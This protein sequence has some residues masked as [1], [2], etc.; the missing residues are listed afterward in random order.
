MKLRLTTTAIAVAAVFP[1]HVPTA[2][3][4]DSRLDTVVVT[5]TRQTQRVDE[6]LASVDVITRDEIERAGSRTLVEVLAGRP[7]VQVTSNGGAGASSSV[8]IRGAN[9][10]HTLLLIDGMRVG[11]ATS[12][13]PA[14]ETIPLNLIE[15]VEILRGPAS[16]LYGADAL[17]G[18]IQ[19]VTRRDVSGFQPRVHIGTGTWDTYT[20]SAGVSG[21]VERLRYSLDVGHDRTRGFDA[22]PDLKG[23][24]TGDR[25]GWKNDYFNGRLSLGFRDRDEIG[26]SHWETGGRNWYDSTWPTALFDHYIDKRSQSSSVFA[27]NELREGWQSTLRVGWSEDYS[28]AKDSPAPGS[29]RLTKQQQIM[30]QHDLELGGGN[31]MLAIERLAQSVDSSVQYAQTKRT[32]NSLM[33]GWGRQFDRHDMQVNVRRDR[34]SQFGTRSTGSLAY[35]YQVNDELRLLGSVGTGFRAPSFNELYHPPSW[36]GQGNPNLEPEKSFNREVGLRWSRGFS[37]VE[38]TY[39][40]NRVHGL[41]TG[42]SPMPQNVNL[43]KL[44][45]V[46]LVART[47]LG[48]FDL[49]AGLDLLNARDDGTGNRLARRARESGFVRL[50]TDLRAWRIGGE[51]TGQSKR[52]DN[53]AN[54]QDISGYGVMNLYAD[55]RFGDEWRLELRANNVLDKKYELAR[56]YATARANAFVGVRYTPR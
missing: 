50:E 35:G 20:A 18:V 23:G 49:T 10:G 7:G 8:F 2:T 11:S 15:R 29:K 26:L 40:N 39:F 13:A 53:A 9:S 34:N 21:G 47:R 33:A 46:E 27:R 4:Q 54:T 38:V 19:I 44:K 17:G 22:Q 51:V 30:W 42:W 31:L 12:G 24:T 16:S 25:D 1:M 5:A 48:S 37:N 52:Y 32:I 56:G 28:F 36:G 3:A 6:V 45:G 14:W 43:A 55:Y 41:I